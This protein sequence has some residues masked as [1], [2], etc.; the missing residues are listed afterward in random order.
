MADTGGSYKGERGAEVTEYQEVLHQVK[1]TTHNNMF[2]T[3]K[4]Q[5]DVEYGTQNRNISIE[6]LVFE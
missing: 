6:I 2:E 3:D 4:C 5:R 1:V